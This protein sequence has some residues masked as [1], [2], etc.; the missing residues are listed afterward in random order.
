MIQATTTGPPLTYSVNP[1]QFDIDGK[2]L[3][4]D[5]KRRKALAKQ[6]A[7]ED[8]KSKKATSKKSSKKLSP[9]VKAKVELTFEDDPI[10][11]DAASCVDP[12][13]IRA[14]RLPLQVDLEQDKDRMY[15]V[16][17]KQQTATKDSSTEAGKPGCKGKT[18]NPQVSTSD[19]SLQHHHQ[20]QAK[21][22]LVKSN[23]LMISDFTEEEQRKL[24]AKLKQT[25]N[26]IQ[27]KAIQP[28]L[29]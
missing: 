14:V 16:K 6:K 15:R 22:N 9:P 7:A 21:P 24:D 2:R 26:P 23:D 12:S 1:L 29:C 27:Y 17:C 20:Q 13:P 5:L 3:K 4:A 25:K 8:K 11:S 28:T 18:T 10:D 19:P